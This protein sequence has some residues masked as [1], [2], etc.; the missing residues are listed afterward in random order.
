MYDHLVSTMQTGVRV[1]GNNI[2]GTLHFIEG[3]LAPSGYLSGDGNFLALKLLSD[4]WAS[5]DSV[6]VGLDPSAG[7]GLVEIKDDPD[8]N[9]VAKVAGEIDH[10]QQVFK[11]VATKGEDTVTTV[12]NLRLTLETE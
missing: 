6:L 5:Y 10:V 11:V 3:G 9:L 12:Y 2:Y 1:V 8:H 4:E 7:S